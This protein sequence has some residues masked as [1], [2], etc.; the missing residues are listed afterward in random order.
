LCSQV[1]Q[2]SSFGQNIRHEHIVSS[3]LVSVVVPTYN[4]GDCIERTIDSA[5]DKRTKTSRSLWWMMVPPMTPGNA[6]KGATGLIGVFR[7]L[8]QENRGV[9][10]ARNTGLQNVRG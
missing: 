5:L 2:I 4:R 9:S 10:A 7:Y 8:H 6:S 3:S 1:I